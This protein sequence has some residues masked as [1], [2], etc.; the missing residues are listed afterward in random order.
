MA[1]TKKKAKA[2]KKRKAKRLAPAMAGAAGG[3]TFP[4]VAVSMSVLPNHPMSPLARKAVKQRIDMEVHQWA[5][6]DTAVVEAPTN[7]QV[8][9]LFNDLADINATHNPYFTAIAFLIPN[10]QAWWLSDEPDNL[11]RIID[12]TGRPPV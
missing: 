11:D 2:G 3:A 6:D 9:A 1:K 10:G 7:S 4:Y 12:I 5:T 8:V